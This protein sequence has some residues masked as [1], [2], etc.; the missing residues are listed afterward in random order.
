MLV[1]GV[2]CLPVLQGALLVGVV[3]LQAVRE[4][5]LGLQDVA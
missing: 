2:E 4:A 1:P 5:H 3:T